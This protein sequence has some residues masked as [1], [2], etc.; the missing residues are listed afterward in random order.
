MRYIAAIILALVVVPIPASAQSIHLEGGVR[1]MVYAQWAQGT[2]ATRI[3]NG[4]ILNTAD[5]SNALEGGSEATSSVFSIRGA[6]TV[7]LF[8]DFAELSTDTITDIS[9]ICETAIDEA[10]SS[11]W[12]VI[13][14]E[15]CTSGACTVKQAT[16][17][18]ALTDDD[19]WQ[20]TYTVSAPWMRCRFDAAGTATVSTL[21]VYAWLGVL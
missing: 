8:F 1:R 13:T 9:W 17:A 18:Y 10:G 14:S 12:H 16:H 7:T 21:A 15:S 2:P 4:K 19:E 20:Y 11:G 6:N 5:L 3:T